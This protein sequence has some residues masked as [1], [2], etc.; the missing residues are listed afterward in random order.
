[1]SHVQHILQSA[2]LLCPSDPCLCTF[3]SSNLNSPWSSGWPPAAPPPV[4]AIPCSCLA[5]R[6][7]PAGPRISPPPPSCTV[8]APWPRRRQRASQGTV[9]AYMVLQLMMKED[10]WGM[11][12]PEELVE[13]GQLLSKG[14][15]EGEGGC[16]LN[17][18]EHSGAFHRG[19][20]LKEASTPH[21]CPACPEGWGWGQGIGPEEGRDKRI[22]WTGMGLLISGPGAFLFSLSPLPCSCS[23]PA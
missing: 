9:L 17:G 18:P 6:P 20:D 4:P 10:R 15:E 5:L 16:F 23:V 21:L 19:P 12:R 13:E 7:L 14:Q 11:W 22:T 2:F 3:L 1:M 8:R